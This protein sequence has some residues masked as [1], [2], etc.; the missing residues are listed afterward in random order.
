MKTYYQDIGA[1]PHTKHLYRTYSVGF[2][3]SLICT[4]AAYWLAVSYPLSQVT[5]IAGIV[6]LA[7]V[8]CVVQ[9]VCFL[10]VSAERRSRL[11]LLILCSTLT[12]VG[13]LISGSLWIMFT[14]NGRMMP[15]DAQMQQY[16]Q[17]EGG[18]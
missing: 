6:G 3:L 4:F 1:L 9:A 10:H 7:L 16:M 11:K 8:Q 13:I 5:L 18:F 15:N 14:L 17:N 12:V 2:A